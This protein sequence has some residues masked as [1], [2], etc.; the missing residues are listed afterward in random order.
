MRMDQIDPV[1]TPKF[2]NLAHDPCEKKS[3]RGRKSK[4]TRQR[5]IAKPLRT[6]AKSLYVTLPAV[7][8]LHRVNGVHQTHVGERIERLRDEA[9]IRV[10]V[11][12]EERRVGK[13]G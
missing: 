1:Q 12:S 3:A 8:R 6:H 11:R 7:N 10:V 2:A 9:T 4:A 5:Q 13:E